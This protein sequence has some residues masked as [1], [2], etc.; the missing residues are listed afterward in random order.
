MIIDGIVN[1][2]GLTVE[3]SGEGLRKVESGNV[4]HYAF[5]YLIGALAIAA[6]YAYWVM[7]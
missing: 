3:G 6:Y 1:G 5:V 7:R 4:Q 2:T